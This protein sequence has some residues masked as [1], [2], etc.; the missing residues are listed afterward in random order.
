MASPSPAFPPLALPIQNNP[1]YH[2]VLLHPSIISIYIYNTSQLR[3]SFHHLRPA[4][5]IGN[6][7][8]ALCCSYTRPGLGDVALPFPSLTTYTYDYGL[9]PF[10]SSL[11]SVIY[12]ACCQMP[13][14]NLRISSAH[15]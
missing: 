11:V 13:Q 7:S 1:R 14:D 12:S 9:G 8:H 3:L 2:T 6:L 5:G 10:Y 15:R 4:L